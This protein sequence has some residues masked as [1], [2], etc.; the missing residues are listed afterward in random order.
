M[1]GGRRLPEWRRALGPFVLPVGVGIVTTALYTVFSNLQ[2]RSFAAPSWDLGIFTQL[3][4]QYAALEAPIVTIKGE[5]FN[6]LGDHFHPLLVVLGP[7]FAIFPHAFTLLVVQNAMLGI[8]AAALA[9]AAIR[10]LGSLT[11][12]LFGWR[13]RSALVCKPRSRR[14]STRSLLPFRCWRCL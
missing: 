9:H 12:T 7:I 1:G 6:L 13:L 3:A 10:L 8:A 2:W 11:G 14:S 4:R 5:S